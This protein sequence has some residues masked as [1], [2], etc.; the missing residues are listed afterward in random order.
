MTNYLLLSGT[1][2]HSDLLIT[3]IIHMLIYWFRSNRWNVQLY[4]GISQC[5]IGK[6][7][8]TSKFSSNVDLLYEF[9]RLLNIFS[10]RFL[11]CTKTFSQSEFMSL[12]GHLL[13]HVRESTEKSRKNPKFYENL[14]FHSV[15]KD[16]QVTFNQIRGVLNVIQLCVF[17]S[18]MCLVCF[19]LDFMMEFF[20]NWSTFYGSKFRSHDYTRKTRSSFD[21]GTYWSHA[22]LHAS[23]LS[24]STGRYEIEI[25]NTSVSR[26]I[27]KFRSKQI[28]KLNSFV[29]ISAERQNIGWFLTLI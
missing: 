12:S 24:I 17:K 27:R 21:V 14:I 20:L 29:E 11:N 10:C 26:F 15:P 7:Q 23:S 13:T 25:H 9:R 28:F 22:P 1:K 8:H 18:S 6:T 4:C 5:S 16:Q 3:Q 2:N 19:L